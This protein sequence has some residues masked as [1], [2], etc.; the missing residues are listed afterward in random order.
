MCIIFFLSSFRKHLKIGRSLI[1]YISGFWEIRQP[2]TLYLHSHMIITSSRRTQS[3]PLYKGLTVLSSLTQI[4]PG[5]PQSHCL[6]SV[7]SP[8][9]PTVLSRVIGTQLVLNI[10]L[11]SNCTQHQLL[12]SLPHDRQ[13]LLLPPRMLLTPRV[14]LCFQSYHHC[15]HILS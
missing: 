4:P 3:Y 6:I 11:S 13:I 7:K 5:P 12:L 1:K 8:L 9:T 15:L 2:A 10:Y 14:T